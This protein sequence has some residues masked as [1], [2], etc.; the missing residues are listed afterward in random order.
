MVTVDAEVVEMVV[1]VIISDDA[2]NNGFDKSAIRMKVKLAA[3]R[4]VANKLGWVN[5]TNLTI[6]DGD[7]D[8]QDH[9]FLVRYNR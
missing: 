2:Y 9:V 7:V 4:E 1:K 8:N 5:P 3:G 6:I